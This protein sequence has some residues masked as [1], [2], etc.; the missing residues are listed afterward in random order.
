MKIEN[1]VP[2]I[3]SV[4]LFNGV[5]IE[6]AKNSHAPARHTVEDDYLLTTK[7]FCGKC[8]TMMVAQAGTSNT[9]K[10][11]RYYACVR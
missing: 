6:I 4:E 2:A 11:H 9:G 1:A 10:V 7:F 8:D 3:V 5:Q